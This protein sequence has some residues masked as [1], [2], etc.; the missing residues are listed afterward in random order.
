MSIAAHIV[1]T[2]L[3]VLRQ[4]VAAVMLS[5]S[6]LGRTLF[7]ATVSYLFLATAVQCALLY[8][9]GY[10]RRHNRHDHTLP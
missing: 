10:M 8:A 1:E 4:T 5:A 9:D 7:P 3:V 6:D 2:L